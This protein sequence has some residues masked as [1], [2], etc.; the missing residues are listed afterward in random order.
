MF[1]KYVSIKLLPNFDDIAVSKETCPH[2]HKYKHYHH[3]EMFR[4]KTDRISVIYHLRHLTKQPPNNHQNASQL[5]RT[6]L[7]V[8]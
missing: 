1:L 3:H 6:Q 7:R 2:A 4:I 8:E 5:T